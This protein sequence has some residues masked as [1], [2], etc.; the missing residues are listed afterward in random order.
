MAGEAVSETAPASMS[1][2]GEDRASKSARCCALSVNV[3]EVPSDWPA[4]SRPAREVPPD[5]EPLSRMW[6]LEASAAD[7]ATVSLNVT[8]SA[9]L[10]PSYKADAK[11]GATESAVTAMSWPLG[12][13]TKALPDVS[14]TVLGTKYRLGSDMPI[15]D[16]RGA[17]SRTNRTVDVFDETASMESERVS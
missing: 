16:W 9:P 2:S 7:A 17:S 4:S 12:F 13:G 5:E 11:R 6:N 3:T 8:V 10:E 15:T 1:S 14:Y